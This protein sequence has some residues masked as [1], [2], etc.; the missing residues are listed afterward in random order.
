MAWTLEP[1]LR[2]EQNKIAFMF[3][4]NRLPPHDTFLWGYLAQ[5]RFSMVVRSDR[6][7]VSAMSGEMVERRPA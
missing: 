3:W 5:N 7:R 2:N 6:V 4:N 1:Q